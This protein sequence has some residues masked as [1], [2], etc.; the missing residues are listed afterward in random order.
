[1]KT[2]LLKMRVENIIYMTESADMI[3]EL[4][5]RQ[6]MNLFYFPLMTARKLNTKLKR[7]KKHWKDVFSA[8]I[9]SVWVESTKELEKN[10]SIADKK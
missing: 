1:M 9:G 10:I 7:L 5:M 6:A 3:S 8:A 2:L 4:D